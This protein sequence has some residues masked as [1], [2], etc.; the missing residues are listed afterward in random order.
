MSHTAALGNMFLHP[1]GNG[2]RSLFSNGSKDSQ[3]RSCFQSLKSSSMT[4]DVL[5]CKFP[6]EL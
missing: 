6:K 4:A 5:H 3:Q 2:Y 1:E